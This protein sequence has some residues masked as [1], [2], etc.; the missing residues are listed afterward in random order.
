MSLTT[1]VEPAAGVR[2]SL[3]TTASY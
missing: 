1:G 2:I 3:F